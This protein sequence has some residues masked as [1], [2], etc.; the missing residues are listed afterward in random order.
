MLSLVFRK[1]VFFSLLLVLLISIALHFF[2]LVNSLGYEFAF[3]ISFVIAFIAVFT[4]SEIVS[5]YN[6][7]MTFA[8]SR[9]EDV[10][11]S[12]LLLNVFIL[13]IPFI[14]G[15]IGS[16]FNN[17]CYFKEGLFFFL[18]LPLITTFLSTAIGSFCGY[19]FGR[20]GFI[21]GS[22]IIIGLILYSLS[23]LYFKP[24]LFFYNPILGYFPGPIYDRV[25]PIDKTLV[26]YRGLVAVAGLFIFKLVQIMPGFKNYKFGLHNLVAI[27]VLLLVLI[28]GYNHRQEIGFTY[29]RDFIQNNFL[30][31][32]IETDH[33]YIHYSPY[34]ENSENIDLIASD[35]EWRFY[36]LSSFLNTS[37][38]SK[39]HSYIFPDE[40][41]RKKLIGAG[42]TTI[43]NPVHGE[44]HLVYD[45][46][47][48]G[49]LKHELVHVMSA[50]FGTR[51]LK[52]SPSYGLVEGLAVAAD[53]DSEGLSG[54]KL[55]KS[56]VESGN[57]PEIEDLLDFGFL[58]SP[59]ATSY[60]LM[61]SFCRYLIDTYGIDKF[62]E[63][64]KSGKT[65]VYG[66]S[67]GQLAASW[68]TFLKDIPVNKKEKELSAY[69]LS[70]KGLFGSYCPRVVENYKEKG[71]GAYKENN[72]ILA[73]EYFNDALEVD[74][75]N[76][77]LKTMLAYSYYYQGEFSELDSRAEE[78][79]DFKGTNKNIIE[80]LKANIKWVSGDFDS[81]LSSFKKLKNS[82]LPDDIMREIDIKIYLENFNENL[83]NAFADYFSSREKVE[84]TSILTDVIQSYPDFSPAYYLLGRIHF[85]ER[86]YNRASK[87]F[88]YANSIGLPT[89]NLQTENLRLLGM[90]HYAAGR[91]NLALEAFE[92]YI[93]RYPESPNIGYVKD[94][95]RRTKWTSSN[96]KQ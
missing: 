50:E 14:S 90:S 44:I 17:Y 82:S 62:K 9:I 64:Y 66:K 94:F 26:L 32:T 52:I 46:F 36:E 20:R 45:E 30:T 47:P 2:P 77:D 49:V 71:I 76:T 28:F 63:F 21:V 38:Q 78:F 73:S 22:F 48:L 4:S 34:F 53:W 56:L 39:I 96:Y 67:I 83:R 42:N 86:N 58:Y 84:R 87:Y 65:S 88:F 74:P 89:E 19:V 1:K 79:A 68:K 91:Y 92:E 60:T 51:L 55:S 72:T 69:R 16:S 23:E 81:A 7:N 31:K 95:I 43:A 93:I 85:S 35:H 70:D 80:N 37:S 18:L 15:L 59:G 33:F 6:S 25:I 8:R 24:H 10:I 40:S 5:E 13:S 61:G 27:L 11:Y 3:V 12:V 54:H 57:A 41:M 75:D 29:S